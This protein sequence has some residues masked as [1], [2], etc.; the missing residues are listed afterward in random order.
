[1]SFSNHKKNY[2]SY[3]NS[4]RKTNSNIN[5]EKDLLKHSSI[6]IPNIR[7]KQFLIKSNPLKIM[8][9]K[10]Q[11]NRVLNTEQNFYYKNF[12]IFKN[13]IKNNKNNIEFKNNKN[14]NNIIRLKLNIP[15]IDILSLDN[16]AKNIIEKKKIENNKIN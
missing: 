12:N 16:W 8:E 14:N 15:F 7:K 6:F 4:T 10:Y 11:S 3:L 5:N 1:M 2:S 9:K 13:I